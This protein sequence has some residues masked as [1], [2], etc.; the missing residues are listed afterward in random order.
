MGRVPL[1]GVVDALLGRHPAHVDE[2][3]VELLALRAGV[4][5]AI[6]RNVLEHGTTPIAYDLLEAMMRDSMRTLAERIW[7]W[8]LRNTYGRRVHGKGPR[9]KTCAFTWR[10][11][12]EQIK[13]DRSD[14]SRAGRALLAS[15]RL[16]LDARGH[17]GIQKDPDKWLEWTGIRSPAFQP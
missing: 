10:K 5:R 7:T 8:V 14:T 16:L 12:A 1:A 17:V 3:G 4:A 13:A 2:L 15:K 11:I 6:H 9:R